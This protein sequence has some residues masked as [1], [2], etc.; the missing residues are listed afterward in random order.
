[1]A[2]SKILRLRSLR[3]SFRKFSGFYYVDN[4]FSYTCFKFPESLN[5]YFS[6]FVVSNET[7]RISQ[8]TKTCSKLTTKNTRIA[9]VDVISFLRIF[10]VCD[11]IHFY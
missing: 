10:E 4:C 7:L 8:Q 1:M 6:E 9:S 11:G 5:S 2:A 3:V